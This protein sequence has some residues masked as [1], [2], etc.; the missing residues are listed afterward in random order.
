[1]QFR[2][3]PATLCFYEPFNG[4][5]A[6]LTRDLAMR[7]RPDSWNSGHPAGEPYLLEYLPL[8]GSPRGVRSYEAAME[9]EWYVPEG[10]LKGNL[11]AAERRYVGSLLQ[12]ARD[13]DRIP[14]LGF[15]RSL[16]RLAPLKRH[17]SGTHIFQR[18]NVWSQWM[19]YLSQR[20][21]G[22]SWFCQT[23]LETSRCNDDVYLSAIRDYYLKRAGEQRAPL[24]QKLSTTQSKPAGADIQSLLGL[25]DADLFA[26]FMAVHLYLY[27]HAE[28]T[29]DMT[30][31][32]TRLGLEPAYRDDIRQEIVDRTGIQLSLADARHAQQFAMMEPAAIDWDEIEGHSQ[33]AVRALG[34]ARG[35]A[36]R[37]EI[38]ARLLDATRAEMAQSERYLRAARARV[39]AL[40][41][42]KAQMVEVQK[43]ITT[44]LSLVGGDDLLV[45]AIAKADFVFSPGSNLATPSCRS[46]IATGD[47]G[48]RILRLSDGNVD[49]SSAGKTGG[50]SIRVPDAFE[51]LASGRN[52]RVR[53]MARA[54]QGAAAARFA[55]AYSTNEVGNSGWRWFN[56]TPQWSIVEMSYSVPQM[57]NG[58]GDFIGLLP[59]P[60]L[61]PGI[62]VYVVTAQVP[63]KR[64][65]RG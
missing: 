60:A 24:D 12:H 56:V 45:S 29:A 14:V 35:M 21:D 5:L 7:S 55:I 32:A 34:G 10:G 62:E 49:A 58:N 63:Q 1:M 48:R 18:R 15:C 57:K 23:I 30:V 47:D 25:P 19:S 46:S 50:F 43:A 13:H 9:W 20:E 52:I 54:A 17:F 37:E 2:V 28:T 6:T 39:D 27:I 31:D 3:I 26:M 53:V 44:L 33:S 51:R 65:E 38:A 42:E 40:I 11:R 59:E 64:A 36:Q 22:N 16:G 8:L 61:A 41:A 4:G